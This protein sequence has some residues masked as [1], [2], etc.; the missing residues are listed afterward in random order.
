[1]RLTQ[2]SR[3]RYQWFVAENP[4]VNAFD[5]PGGVIVVHTGLLKAADSVGEVAGVLAHEIQHV[6]QRHALRAMIHEL[7]WRAVLAL[8]LGD[9]SGG[10]WG[11]LAGRLGGL[12]YGRDLERAADLGGLDALRRA[13]IAPD[14]MLDFFGKLAR[15]EGPGVALLASHPATD[16]RIE[17]LRRAIATRGAYPVHAPAYDWAGARDRKSVV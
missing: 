4:E 15:R 7:G 17:A 14:G 13:G 2:G 10:V 9:L 5:L 8:A 16:E 3:Y 12:S 11:D 1:M 6:E